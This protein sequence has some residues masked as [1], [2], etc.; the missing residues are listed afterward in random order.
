MKFL[1]SV[2]TLNAVEIAAG[3]LESRTSNFSKVQPLV[4]FHIFLIIAFIFAIIAVLVYLVKVFVNIH[5]YNHILADHYEALEGAFKTLKNK[6]IFADKFDLE[7]AYSLMHPQKEKF[8]EVNAPVNMD[9]ESI[10]KALSDGL[11]NK[12]SITSKQES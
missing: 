11:L 9:T 8:I 4:Y 5:R 6:E 3:K 1:D 2:K 12:F 7:K 10:T